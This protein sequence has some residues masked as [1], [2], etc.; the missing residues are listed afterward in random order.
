[1]SQ[2]DVPEGLRQVG[3][4]IGAGGLSM[5][6]LKVIERVFA[7]DDREAND[8]A[9]ITSELRQDIRELRSL[10]AQMEERLN[11]ER[12][13]GVVLRARLARAEIR[14]QWVR[15]RYHR[16]VG[17]IQSEPSLPQPPSYLF[18]DIPGELKG[19]PPL[20]EDAHA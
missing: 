20:D 16:L 4:L 12:E 19:R 18:E 15:N 1:M 10:L 7:R 3:A 9:A 14:E 17:W 5:L 2:I 13:H 11:E 8:R 6:L